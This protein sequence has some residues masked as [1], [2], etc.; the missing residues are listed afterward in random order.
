MSDH[1][2]V[3]LRTRMSMA[4][5]DL[6]AAVHD[7]ERVTSVSRQN[8]MNAADV[9]DEARGR[10][11]SMEQAIEQLDRG[12]PSR[13]WKAW[14][15]A[16]VVVAVVAACAV[17]ASAQSTQPTTQPAATQPAIGPAEL[18]VVRWIDADGE[19]IK[20]GEQIHYELTPSAHV[21][22]LKDRLGAIAR[23]LRELQDEHRAMLQFIS[24]VRDERQPGAAELNLNT[25][26]VEQLVALDVEQ[27]AA[28]RAERIVQHRERHGPFER[29]SDL[30]DVPYL[31]HEIV[32]DLRGRVRVAPVNTEGPP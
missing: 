5:G 6:R 20:P 22:R 29:L 19:R 11:G 4:S 31:P 27:L 9:M 16:A 8:V 18:V 13:S 32:E 7:S 12:A 21:E 23:K 2:T 14:V 10:L 3:G 28:G 17:L 26:T 1:E 15:I 25:A 30:Y 24:E